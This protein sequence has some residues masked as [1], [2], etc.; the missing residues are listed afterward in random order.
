M[1]GDESGR[2]NRCSLEVFGAND[3]LTAS[4]ETV[5]YWLGGVTTLQKLLYTPSAHA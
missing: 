5:S 1:A 3:K 4:T 2:E